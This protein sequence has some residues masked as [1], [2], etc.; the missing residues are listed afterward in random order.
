MAK[1]VTLVLGGVGVKGVA[2]IGTLQSLHEHKVKINN[3]VA[4]GISALIG[5]QFALNRDLGLLTEHFVRFFTENHR[6]LWGLE[7]LG[8]LLDGP[9]RS[10]ELA[11]D[12]ALR[13]L[14]VPTKARDIPVVA[15]HDACLGSRRRAWQPTPPAGQL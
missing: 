5:A 12:R 1:G 13:L 8:G 14:V 3:I 11:H 10:R 6:Y 7:Q 2:N 15:V 9:D 4:T